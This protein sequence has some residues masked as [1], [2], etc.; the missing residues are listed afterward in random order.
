MIARLGD[1]LRTTLEN[2][3]QQEVPFRQELGFIQPYLDIEKARLGSRLTVDLR[4]DPAV[5]DAKVPNLILHPLVENAIRHGI[6]VQPAAGRIEI[7]AGREDGCLQLVVSD[8]GPGLRM[9]LETVKG[10]GL[11][12]TRARLEQL[13]GSNQR[14]DLTNGPDGGLRV[15]ITIPFEQIQCDGTREAP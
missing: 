6:A 8:S 1:L 11:A 2:A 14:L 5:M 15:A 4:I 12:N 9:P 3:S 10:I 13:Y 7:K